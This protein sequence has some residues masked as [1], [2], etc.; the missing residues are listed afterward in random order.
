MGCLKVIGIIL[1]CISVLGLFGCLFF[2]MFTWQSAIYDYRS[3]PPTSCRVR[4]KGY[5]DSSTECSFCVDINTCNTATCLVVTVEYLAD[6]GVFNTSVLHPKENYGI[7]GT[8]LNVSDNNII[9]H[10]LSISNCYNRF[11]TINVQHVVRLDSCFF[12][13]K[14]YLFRKSYTFYSRTKI[15]LLF[16]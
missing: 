9:F 5:S 14:Y 12:F 10:V 2:P 13:G 16:E 8:I 3:Y 7:T 1:G 6:G 15:V 4:S 11:E